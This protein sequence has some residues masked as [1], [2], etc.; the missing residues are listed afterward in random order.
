MWALMI[1]KGF[2]DNRER[3][4]SFRGGQGKELR[5]VPAGERGAGEPGRENVCVL[6]ERCRHGSGRCSWFILLRKR[7]Q[8]TRAPS[9]LRR[10]PDLVSVTRL[11]PAVS[12]RIKF[13]DYA[14]WAARGSLLRHPNIRNPPAPIQDF[15]YHDKERQLSSL[16]H[17]KTCHILSGNRQTFASTIDLTGCHRTP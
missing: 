17:S 15:S 11:K 10:A 6:C 16:V 9:S 5:S 8:F 12:S 7:L 14:F 3:R 13:L 2:F 4:F 1:E